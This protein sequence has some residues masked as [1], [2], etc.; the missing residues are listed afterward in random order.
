MFQRIS[1]LKKAVSAKL[2]TVLAAGCAVLGVGMLASPAHA[3][4]EEGDIELRFDAF[5]R[6][7][8]DFDG[9][10]ISFSGSV[11]WFFSDQF[12]LGLRQGIQYN[13]FAGRNLNADT[14]VFV[15]FHFGGAGNPLQ[16][17]VG[18]SLG[19]FYGD[20]VR[21]TFYAG[22]EAGVKW[23]VGDNQDWFIFGQ[24]EY[25]F[26]FRDSDEASDNIDDGVFNY[27]F[28]LGVLL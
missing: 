8:V 18:A 6:N 17:F 27:R 23:F 13:D 26:F 25:W 24:I 20:N 9:V 15:N 7:S 2:A 1:C 28:G 5:A 19:Y 3:Q 14:S 12:E 10:E 11:G 22:P 21:D 16:P 4:F